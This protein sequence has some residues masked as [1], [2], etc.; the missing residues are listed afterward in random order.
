M[1]L[2]LICR[3]FLRLGPSYTNCQRVL[4]LA[5]AMLSC[6]IV[7]VLIGTDRAVLV[8]GS[9]FFHVKTTKPGTLKPGQVKVIA[10]L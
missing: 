3:R 6:I 2:A 9:I 10:S 7:H 8:H 1:F 5:L 4:T